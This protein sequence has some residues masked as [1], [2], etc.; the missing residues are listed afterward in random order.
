MC[1]A[2]AVLSTTVGVPNGGSNLSIRLWLTLKFTNCLTH[3]E[4]VLATH[5]VEGAVDRS[6]MDITEKRTNSCPSCHKNKVT[7]PIT[8]NET[9]QRIFQ[10]ATDH[11]PRTKY[12]TIRYLS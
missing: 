2:V 6:S 1:D 7:N 4:R 5:G 8:W 10:A 9:D 3:W 12:F 11:N